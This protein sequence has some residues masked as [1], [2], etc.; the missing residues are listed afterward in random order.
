MIRSLRIHVE[1]EQKEYRREQS[2][3]SRATTLLA[4]AAEMCNRDVIRFL[5]EEKRMQVS[6]L[7]ENKE[8]NLHSI[9][10]NCDFTFL[11]YILDV[12]KMK[13]NI[14]QRESTDGY[15]LVHEAV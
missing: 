13:V 4:K 5:V 2:P 11:K 10:R 12:L 1:T 9:A 8:C 3:E 7:E 15:T 14:D 6:L